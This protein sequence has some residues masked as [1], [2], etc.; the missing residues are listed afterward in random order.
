[1]AMAGMRLPIESHV[2]QAF[3]SEGLKP[4]IPG[5]SLL[6]QGIFTAASR[7]RAVLCLVVILMDTIPMHSEVICQLLKMSARAAWRFSQTL[8]GFAYCGCGVASWTCRWMGRRSSI[9]RPLKIYISMVAGVMVALRQRQRQ[10]FVSPT[11]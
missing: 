2:L 7:I 5:S 6:V 11:S 8:V 9:K 4:L 1:M 10:G 3:V